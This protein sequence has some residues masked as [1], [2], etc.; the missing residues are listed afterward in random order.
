MTTA[1]ATQQEQRRAVTEA[2]LAE[3]GTDLAS[4]T[5][6]QFEGGLAKLTLVQDRIKRL[7]GTALVKDIH[8]GDPNGAFKR[9]ILFKSGAQEL[10][11]V[12]R[13]QVRTIDKQITVEP[14]FVSVVVEVVAVDAMG[15]TV[16]TASGACNSKEKRF[17]Q[18]SGDGWTYRDPRETLHDCLAMAEKRAGVAVT[19]EASGAT[20]FFADKDA[21]QEIEE[22]EYEERAVWDGEKKNEFVR[23][24]MKVKGMTKDQMTDW[25]GDFLGDGRTLVYADEAAGVID[26]IGR[27]KP[28]PK[29]ESEAVSN[30]PLDVPQAA[31]RFDDG[32]DS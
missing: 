6:E 16:A 23:I 15:R 28:A 18:R 12:M 26:A 31:S 5:D 9:K 14:D 11:R 17:R 27:W 3:P 7:I 4:L 19:L 24:A 25:L 2:K 1:V 13:L 20:G 32:E 30:A 29:T 10:R 21:I 22:A 8:Y